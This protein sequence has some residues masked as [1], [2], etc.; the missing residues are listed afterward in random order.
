[1]LELLFCLAL[2][3]RDQEKRLSLDWEFCTEL[4]RVV[5]VGGW[6][7]DRL[8]ELV[9]EVDGY[10]LIGTIRLFL[11]VRLAAS[12]STGIVDSAVAVTRRMGIQNFPIPFPIRLRMGGVLADGCAWRSAKVEDKAFVSLLK[13]RL[14]PCGTGLEV[15]LFHELAIASTIL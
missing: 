10:D 12:I 13:S 2:F 5:L 14:P 7:T 3:L 4:V 1:M 15:P 11:F 9:G 8:G 6:A